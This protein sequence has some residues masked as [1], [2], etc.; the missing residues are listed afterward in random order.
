MD[1]F[2][3]SDI[4]FS[5]LQAALQL[6]GPP[7]GGCRFKLGQAL[8]L[9]QLPQVFKDVR[10]AVYVWVHNHGQAAQPWLCPIGLPLVDRQRN[11]DTGR[12]SLLKVRVLPGERWRVR[13]RLPMPAERDRI[14]R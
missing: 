4:E 2:E 8:G 10:S 7:S 11:V 1:A 6:L 5:A 12:D 3:V 13:S 14:Q 9:L